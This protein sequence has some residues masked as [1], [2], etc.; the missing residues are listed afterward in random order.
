MGRPA[1][2]AS[3]AGC[4]KVDTGFSPKSRSNSLESSTFYDFGLIQSKIIVI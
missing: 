2:G 3:R 1:A 4:E